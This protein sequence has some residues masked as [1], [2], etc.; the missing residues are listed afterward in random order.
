MTPLQQY[1][2]FFQSLID[3]GVTIS[4][5]IVSDSTVIYESLPALGT[6][7]RADEREELSYEGVCKFFI[8][9]LT[10]EMYDVISQGMHVVEKGSGKIWRI[11]S[12]RHYQLF[13]VIGLVCYRDDL[14]RARL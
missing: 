1:Q 5:D 14:A 6:D 10:E 2:D 13:G 8:P 7:V 11:V 9:A 12:R 4:V 3:S